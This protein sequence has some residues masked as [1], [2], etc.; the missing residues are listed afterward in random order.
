MSTHSGSFAYQAHAARDWPWA[1]AAGFHAPQRA[2][3]DCLQD[4]VR[5]CVNEEREIAAG[6]LPPALR[7][8]FLTCYANLPAAGDEIGI[9]RHARGLWNTETG[10]V[11]RWLAAR[12]TTS[13]PAR[14]LDAGSGYGTFAMMFALTGAE[15]TGVD[16]RGDRLDV[17]ERRLEMHR[18]S[19]GVA[20]QVRYLLADLT[21]GIGETYDLIWVYNAISHIDPIE[22]FLRAVADHLEPGGLLV[23]GDI[24]GA[25]PAH[26]RRLATKRDE[27]HETY[28]AADRTS[29]HYA[30]ERTFAP[31]ELRGALESQGLRVVRHEVF[32]G[33]ASRLPAP[34]IAAIEP[35]QRCWWMHPR[36]ARRQCV[37]AT[38]A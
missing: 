31:R 3:R 29:H 34:A 7:D 5:W 38:R 20:L 19:R 12:A 15:V 22:P 4:F 24:N 13:S 37:V 11:M 18:V 17:A 33:G 30:V 1:P 9:R 6:W 21:A 25:N 14:V 8:D 32:L 36:L 35:L 16:L 27:V 28:V 23:I 26:L 10:W 2:G